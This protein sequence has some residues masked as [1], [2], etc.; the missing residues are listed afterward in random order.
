[1]APALIR[2]A[3]RA[4]LPALP[5]VER[6]A[7]RRFLGTPMAWVV[8]GP[9]MAHAALELALHQGLL[10]I[11]ETDGTPVGFLAAERQDADLFIMEIS[12]ALPH[13]GQGLG[14]GLMRAAIEAARE[15]DCAGVALTTDS[16]LPWNGPSYTR[17]GF[18][19]LDADELTAPLRQKLRDEEADGMDM[20]RRC[21][22][23]M[24]LRDAKP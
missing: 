14:R 24:A 3:R 5:G 10:W 2:L 21:A 17:L 6:S 12:V 7:A 15:A 16:A 20:L 11:A 23:R 9:V 1:M 22:M 19:V 8:E 13:Q 18:S 4:D